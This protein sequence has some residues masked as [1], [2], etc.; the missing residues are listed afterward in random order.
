MLRKNQRITDDGSANVEY[1]YD[2]WK[3]PFGGL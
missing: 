2:Q 1:I 3:R